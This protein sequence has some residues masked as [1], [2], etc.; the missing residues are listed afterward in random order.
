MSCWDWVSSEIKMIVECRAR[1]GD[2]RWR[3][4]G[5]YR[6]HAHAQETM[7]KLAALQ[8]SNEFRISWRE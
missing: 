4:C 3:S 2:E 8:P 7:Q 5:Y 1:E 6:E